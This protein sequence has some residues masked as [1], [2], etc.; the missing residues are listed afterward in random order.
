MQTLITEC[1]QQCGVLPALRKSHRY[2]IAA[3]VWFSW[4]TEDGRWREGEGTTRE[5]SG[6]GLFILTDTLPEAGASIRVTVVMPAMKVIQPVTFHGY[7]KVVRVESEAGRLFGFAAAVTFDDT[8]N[9]C[10]GDKVG[11]DEEPFMRWAQR[12]DR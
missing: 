8:T 9:Y 4:Q 7:G 3:K 12:Q 10:S 1:G 6:S 2:T 11:L 5:M